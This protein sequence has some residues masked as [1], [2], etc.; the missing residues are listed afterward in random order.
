L[1][2]PADE[3]HQA[4]RQR[5]VSHHLTTAH[6]QRLKKVNQP[7]H[8]SAEMDGGA[9]ADR[10][11][12]FSQMWHASGNMILVP[13]SPSLCSRP[14]RSPASGSTRCGSAT[15]AI[16][17]CVHIALVEWRLDIASCFGAFQSTLSQWMAHQHQV[18]LQ[19]HWPLHVVEGLTSGWSRKLPLVLPMRTRRW[20]FPFLHAYRRPLWS[21]ACGDPS[22]G[23][24]D[25]HLR[26][27]CC[28]LTGAFEG[29]IPKSGFTALHDT[30]TPPL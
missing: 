7:L 26:C 30:A 8:Q 20:G 25:R 4:G 5:C 3:N 18:K 10:N 21:V 27:C 12:V 24:R 22:G 11:L 23:G 14:R 1:R 15:Q 6:L 13:G 16:H 2:S 17:Q 28:V 9:Y 19:E 29:N